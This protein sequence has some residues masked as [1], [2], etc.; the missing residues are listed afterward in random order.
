[1]DR[2]QI[3]WFLGSMRQRKLLSTT[4][5]VLTLAVGILIGTV[6]SNGV[7]AARQSRGAR[8]AQLLT[9]PDP[10]SVS[11]EFSRIAQQV[12]P[13][14]VNI[15]VESIPKSSE[16]G[17]TREQGM[18]D[19]FRRFF[20]MPD[21]P[22]GRIPFPPPDRRPG[23]GSGVIVDPHGYIITNNH[24]VDGAD[25]IRV[26]LVD[27][28]ELHDAELIGRDIETD[29]AV[30]KIDAQNKKLPRATIGNSTAVNV[31]DWAI[32]VGSP[33]GFRES[34]TVG[35]ISAKAR[36]VQGMGPSRS[37]MKFLQTDAAINPGNSGGPLVNIR[38]EVIGINTAIVSRSG[39]YQGLG[40]ALAS[41]I[42]VDVY[43]QII[44]YGRVARGSI[45]IRFNSDSNLAR[46][47]IYGANDGGVFVSEVTP[48]NG[49]AAEAG[50]QPE[51]VIIEID[52]KPIH[53]GDELIETVAA[54]RV[55][56]TIPII[57]I[58]DGKKMTFQ[59][60]VADRSE[61]FPELGSDARLESEQEEGT[62]VMFGINVQD[63]T[64]AMRKDLDFEEPG[65]VMVKSVE[66]ASFADDIGIQPNDVIVAINRRPVSSIRDVRDIQAGLK[67]GDDVV[68]KVMTR[69]GQGTR[70]RWTPRYPAG[71]L[72]ASKNGDL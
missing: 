4:L 62:E 25:R 26:R 15:R 41:N 64:P 12:R 51:D 42:A 59:V 29:L 69:L 67:A 18:E 68:F 54:T 50:I 57:V 23:E 20:G 56:A 22:N 38:G 13:A 11:N 19:F 16:G 40:F 71:R 53:S 49:P 24:V 46:L 72:P 6:L 9:I 70:A 5:V 27:D 47:R 1:M 39:G 3:R 32:A 37:F 7:D 35:I 60:T 52:G 34:V 66:P 55:G 33:F 43:N 21:D 58:R 17:S 63:L 8:D 14:V 31:G 45:G 44:Q 30:I 36:E 48:S 28:D 61:L 65:G 2:K 10:V